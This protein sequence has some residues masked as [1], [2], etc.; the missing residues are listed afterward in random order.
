MLSG[1]SLA[2][3]GED[4]QKYKVEKV[5]DGLN[6]KKIRHHNTPLSSL[7]KLYCENDVRVVMAYIQEKIENFNSLY[8]I[9]YY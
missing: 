2:K 7:E 6:Y 3:L 5:K 4:L 1:K 8:I 9:C